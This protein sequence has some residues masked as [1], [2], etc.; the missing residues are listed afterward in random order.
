MKTVSENLPANIEGRT[1]LFIAA[2]SD[3]FRR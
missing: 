2:Q 1:N 3:H